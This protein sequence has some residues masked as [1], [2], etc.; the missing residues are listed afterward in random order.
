MQV[1]GKPIMK[2]STGIGLERFVRGIVK[3]LPPRI[4]Y[5]NLRWHLTGQDRLARWTDQR[6]Q[7]GQYH[8]LFI[9]GLNNSGTTLVHDLL[10]NHPAMRW[11]PNEGQYLTSGLPLPRS[12]DVPRN[13]SRR[14]DVFHWTEANEPGPA[15]RVKYDWAPLYQPRPGIL[16]EKSPPNILRSRW[17]Q[18]NFQ[19]S[20]FL[21][22]I[23]HPY[24]VCEGI[25]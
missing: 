13:F 21:G 23:R 8:W 4:V 2:S 25:R 14:M 3:K 6:L 24:A 12:Y 22:I 18:Q 7:L 19:P 1:S 20:R 11:L 16:L 5:H 17:L 9:L 10:K 15:L